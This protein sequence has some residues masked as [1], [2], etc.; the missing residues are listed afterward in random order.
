MDEFSKI[1]HLS[2]QKV[3]TEIGETNSYVFCKYLVKKSIS[4][5]NQNRYRSEIKS[6]IMSIISLESISTDNIHLI[7]NIKI[8]NLLLDLYDK[9]FFDNLLKTQ[10]KIH[11]CSLSMCINNRCSKTAG[12]CKWGGRLGQKCFTIELSSKTFLS[13]FQ[14]T[15]KRTSGGLN[16]NDILDCLMLTFEH[17]L[18]HALVMCFC[19][20]WA[21]DKKYLRGSNKYNT[22]PYTKGP[23]KW[24]GRAS[25][26]TGHSKT[27][28]TILNNLFGQTEYL[29]GLFGTKSKEERKKIL[30]KLK[31]GDI[32]T[33]WGKVRLGY[34]KKSQKQKFSATIV[35]INPKTVKAVSKNDAGRDVEWIIPSS[36]ILTI[37]DNPTNNNNLVKP[38]PP[39][40]HTSPNNNHE[41][42]FPLLPKSD[43]NDSK[44]SLP[45]TSPNNREFN[46]GDL[47]KSSPLPTNNHLHISSNTQINRSPKRKNK[48]PTK[49]KIISRLPKSKPNSKN[50]TTLKKY[51]SIINK[52]GNPHKSK[53]V[54]EG[55]CIFPFK[56]KGKIYTNCIDTGN[57]PWCPTIEL[58]PNKNV[59]TWGYCIE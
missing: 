18:I 16:C 12:K 25:A 27:F 28:M 34:R 9:Y 8:L 4:N 40:P 59:S 45:H 35:K 17:E 29:H 46:S 32:I 51:A 11:G 52:K 47:P 23:S 1:V 31:L 58:K 24:T 20:D 48:K 21:Y 33:F 5:E 36:A 22:V 57:G 42:N 7:F 14:E 15:V 43:E 13:A 54:K 55:E 56:Y 10:M 6:E 26:S 19:P 39:P 50:K 41:F 38:P 3:D 53:Y 2:K 49:L 30:T 44:F 37:N